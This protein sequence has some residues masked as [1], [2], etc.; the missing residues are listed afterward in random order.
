MITQFNNLETTIKDTLLPRASKGDAVTFPKLV[1]A[2][3]KT[4]EEKLR[5]QFVEYLEKMDK[6]FRNS[7]ERTENYYVKIPICTLLTEI[8]LFIAL[9]RHYITI[10]RSFVCTNSDIEELSYLLIPVIRF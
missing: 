7:P 6:E 8:P 4:Q 2:I 9:F 10:F 1:E 3:C 5:K